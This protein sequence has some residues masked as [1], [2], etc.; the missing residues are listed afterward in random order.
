MGRQV[1]HYSGNDGTARSPA[2]ETTA[3]KAAEESDKVDVESK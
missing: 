3:K 1:T 2:D